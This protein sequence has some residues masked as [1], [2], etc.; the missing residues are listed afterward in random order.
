MWLAFFYMMVSIMCFSI[1]LCVY[2][3]ICFKSGSFPYVWPVK[4]RQPPVPAFPGH[5]YS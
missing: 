4:V 1:A 2:V 5:G 3:A